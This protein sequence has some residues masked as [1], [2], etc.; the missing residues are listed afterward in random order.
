MSQG[1]LRSIAAEMGSSAEITSAG[2]LFHDRPADSFAAE[3]MKERGIDLSEHRS[4]IV[5]R[6]MLEEADVV[7]TMTREHVRD[8]ALKNKD[9]FRKIFPIK[10]FARR[11][12]GVGRF[13]PG[14]DLDAWLTEVNGDRSPRLY[15]MDL[16][17]DKID[18]PIGGSMSEF[19]ECADG[20]TLLCQTTAK[21][22]F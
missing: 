16:Q 21:L 2:F 3:T 13:E 10:E 18:D 8:A 11:A 20:L 1:I 6:G 14:T 5:N 17:A 19:R 22:L 4:R 9:A 12:T 15:L 7:L